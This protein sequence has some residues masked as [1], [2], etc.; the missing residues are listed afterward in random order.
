MNIDI[1]YRGHLASCDYSC[2]Y[3]PFAKQHDDVEARVR[4]Q[5]ALERF[6]DWVKSCESHHRLHIL[7]T[8][9]G[10]ALI[11]KWYRKAIVELSHLPHVDKVVI[12]TNLSTP[13]EWLREANSDTVAL[14]TTFHPSQTSIEHFV[15]KSHELSALNIIH[16]VGIVGKKAYLS[17]AKAL[18][19]ALAP[20][21]YMWVNAFNDDPSYYHPADIDAFSQLD[22]HFPL[23]ARN[24]L[25]LGKSCRSGS[26][27]IS[28][29]GN[30]DVYPCHFVKKLL[31]NL[32]QQA[33]TDILRPQFSC[34]NQR[35][36][37]YIGYRHLP[38]L[39]LHEIYGDRVLERV[40]S[41]DV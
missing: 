20:D 2:D 17:T 9:W 27:A 10:E 19:A 11:R 38:E 12:Q 18:R 29:D 28:V 16:S 7:F 15:N 13:T 1:T 39:N 26:V 37:C 21:T 22:P 36:N 40:P 35:C 3:C 6:V 34:P 30:G 31:G 41:V 33:L 24:Y 5:Q 25:S 8:P 14:W 4:D 23:N 32:Y